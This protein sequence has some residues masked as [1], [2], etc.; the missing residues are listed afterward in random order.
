MLSSNMLLPILI[1][2]IDVTFSTPTGVYAQNPVNE[3]YGDVS[4]TDPDWLSR[5]S[6]QATP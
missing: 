6:Q 1:P 4:T 2:L 3:R 5:A